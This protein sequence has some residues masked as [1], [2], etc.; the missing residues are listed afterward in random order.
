MRVARSALRGHRRTYTCCFFFSLWRSLKHNRRNSTKLNG[1][2]ING[3]GRTRRR[4]LI[5]GDRVVGWWQTIEKHRHVMCS[6][7][8]I[9]SQTVMR[10]LR[11]LTWIWGIW[12]RRRPRADETTGLSIQQRR[13]SPFWR[14]FGFGNYRKALRSEL[15]AA[16][17]VFGSFQNQ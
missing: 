5:Y 16:G 4:S 2:C 8:F 1:R 14:F 9:G 13:R 6:S 15:K 10:S 11:R 17:N 12:K 3:S 7:I